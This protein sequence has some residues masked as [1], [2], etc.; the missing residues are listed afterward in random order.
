VR[1]PIA[2]SDPRVGRFRADLEALTSRAPTSER[3]LGVAVSG[4]SDSTALLLLA[5]AAFPGAVVAATVDHRLRPEAEQEARQ[6]AALA[7]ELGVPHDILALDWDSAPRSNLQA[8]A[9]EA[10]YRA[11]GRW[12]GDRSCGWLAVAHHVDDQA[13]TLLMRLGRGAGVGGAAGARLSRPLRTGR[14]ESSIRLIRPLLGWRRI[15]LA[16]LVADAGVTPVD[17]PANR[18]P[19]YDR[20]R[21]RQLLAEAP[22]LQPD[23]LA[24]AAG[25]FAE[26]DEAIDWAALKL[27]VERSEID[28]NGSLWLDSVGLPAE[29]Q[30]R[31]LARAIAAIVPGDAPPGPKLG[32]VL[33]ALRAGRTATIAGVKC[34]SGPRWRFFPAP[35]RRNN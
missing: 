29:L 3:R 20:S 35:A 24:A 1:R 33:E 13:E 18:D 28:E 8:L 6:V 22:W 12:A 32:R 26:A 7:A 25:H 15:E 4:G 30:R 5:A 21:A 17:D 34:V 11:L 2:A 10:R 14:D 9:R 23:R 31:L 16:G 19:R 27:W